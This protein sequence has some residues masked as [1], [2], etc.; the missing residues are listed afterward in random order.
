MLNYIWNSAA[1]FNIWMTSEGVQ[2]TYRSVANAY[3]S[4]GAA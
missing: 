4:L 1:V 3:L 2:I